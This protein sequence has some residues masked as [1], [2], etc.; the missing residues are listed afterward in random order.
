MCETWTFWKIL[1]SSKILSTFY[2]SE[3][4]PTSATSSDWHHSDIRTSCS[5]TNTTKDADRQYQWRTVWVNARLYSSA[6]VSARRP[7]MHTIGSY[8][9]HW[10]P[11][12]PTSIELT[13]TWPCS[14][15]WL[16]LRCMGGQNRQ[17]S[18]SQN[19]SIVSKIN[20]RV[21]RL[22]QLIHTHNQLTA[23]TISL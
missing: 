16:L 14:S 12:S 8:L 13:I 9:Y 10:Q 1:P 3:D 18:T 21:H 6:V 5:M 7:T 2:R 19:Q 23:Q 15:A 11:T 22:S 17:N 4:L 20:K